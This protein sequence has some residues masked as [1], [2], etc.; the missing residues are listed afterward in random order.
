MHLARVTIAQAHSHLLFR[1]IPRMCWP[2]VSASLC[3]SALPAP[4]A[5]AGARSASIAQRQTSG[6]QCRLAPRAAWAAALAALLSSG[7]SS[8]CYAKGLPVQRPLLRP[9]LCAIALKRGLWIS[10]SKNVLVGIL[11]GLCLGPAVDVLWHVRRACRG[12]LLRWATRVCR[13]A[14]RNTFLKR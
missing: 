1:A 9:P 6:E 14:A 10:P 8:A 5:L 13:E 3:R 2:A 4:G 11:I 7:G 12:W